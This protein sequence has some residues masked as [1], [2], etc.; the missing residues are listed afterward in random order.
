MVIEKTFTFEDDIFIE[1]F[2]DATESFFY[3]NIATGKS[4]WT[5]PAKYRPYNPK[6]AHELL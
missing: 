1:L 2:D 6:E 5:R 3:T 4:Q